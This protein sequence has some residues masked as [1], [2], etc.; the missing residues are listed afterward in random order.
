MRTLL[1]LFLILLCLGSASV[2]AQ[3]TNSRGEYK[4][5]KKKIV[6]AK[7]HTKNSIASGQALKVAKA[8]EVALPD[9]SGNVKQNHN[10]EELRQKMEDD[11]KLKSSI[12]ERVK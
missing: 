6:N 12:D 1:I 7:A 4:P 10:S 9:E 2:Y 5:E 11:Y 8:S 3:Q